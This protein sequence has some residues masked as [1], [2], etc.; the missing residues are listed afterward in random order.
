MTFAIYHC[1]DYVIT[2]ENHG[3]S[4]L[5]EPE[6]EETTAPTE[7]TT[8]PPATE[9]ETIPATEVPAVEETQPAPE[10][11]QPGLDGGIWIAVAA[12]VVAAAVVAVVLIRKKKK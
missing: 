7:E 2:S 8:V 11:E 3:E 12:V 1:S 9:P 10:V 5:P 4:Y 6:V